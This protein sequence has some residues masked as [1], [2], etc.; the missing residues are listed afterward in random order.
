MMMSIEEEPKNRLQWFYDECVPI[1]IND[2][3]WYRVIE[4]CR[5]L[6]L[7]TNNTNNI[8]ERY[9][10]YTKKIERGNKNMNVISLPGI[11]LLM[12]KS[13]RPDALNYQKWIYSYVAN[14][15]KDTHAQNIVQN[16]NVQI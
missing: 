1:L 8:L 3:E 7:T 15:I 6:H 9:P 14:H 11:V 12:Y 4:V 10:E 5:T 2:E 13:K 16:N